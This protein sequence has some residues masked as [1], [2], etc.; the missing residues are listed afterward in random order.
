MIKIADFPLI[1]N[2]DNVTVDRPFAGAKTQRLE[3]LY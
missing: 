1:R 3:K 2:R